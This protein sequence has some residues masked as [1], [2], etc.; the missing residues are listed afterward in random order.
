MHTKKTQFDFKNLMQPFANYL[1][2]KGWVSAV[3]FNH[4]PDYKSCDLLYI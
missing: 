2:T 4:K 3:G 1:I